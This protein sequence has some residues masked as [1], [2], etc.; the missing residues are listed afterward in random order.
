MRNKKKHYNVLCCPIGMH[1][2][3]SLGYTNAKFS[4]ARSCYRLNKKKKKTIE[5]VTTIKQIFSQHIIHVKQ[6]N[7]YKQC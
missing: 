1:N 3:S 2:L 6:Q 4:C 7:T 5:K